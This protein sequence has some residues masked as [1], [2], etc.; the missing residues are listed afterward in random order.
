M[1]GNVDGGKAEGTSWLLCSARRDNRSDGNRDCRPS[2]GASTGGGMACLT[3]NMDEARAW[4]ERW[5]RES[6][7]DRREEGDGS[8]GEK[9][10]SR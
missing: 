7:E 1:K 8:G 10:D 2:G 9:Q 3:E 5:K 4:D 6:R